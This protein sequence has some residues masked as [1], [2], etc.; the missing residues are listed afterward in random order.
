MNNYSQP[1]PGQFLTSPPTHFQFN[2]PTQTPLWAADLMK[3]VQVITEKVDEIDNIEK[4]VNSIS[5]KMSELEQK[6]KD[7][8]CRVQEV[9]KTSSFRCEK[10]E[11]Q[12][13]TIQNTRDE[14]T[15]KQFE[16][17]RKSL[18]QTIEKMQK[19]QADLRSKTL[20]IEFRNMKK[21][22]IF[23]GLPETTGPTE[24]ITRNSETSKISPVSDIE[25][26]TQ[27]CTSLVKDYVITKLCIDSNNM[28]FDRA[29][30]LGNHI[31]FNRLRPIIVK[32]HYFHD[33][34]LV[35]EASNRKRADLKADNLGVSVQIPKEWRY[36]RQKLSTVFREE[37]QKGNKV[38]FVGEHLHKWRNL[39]P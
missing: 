10:S 20:D 25:T 34:E 23:Y 11:T 22:L 33:R 27:L 5:G 39:Q 17:T 37:K 21:N 30:R 19:D 16:K 9:E 3:D 32:F 38:K 12:A 26:E 31:K 18:E 29:H 35:R 4:T 28:V 8:D 6:V 24:N 15:C 7:I 13:A 1:F 14:L 36:S 2:Q